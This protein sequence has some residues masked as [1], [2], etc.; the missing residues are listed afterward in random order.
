LLQRIQN[1]EIAG[2][3]SAAIV[4]DVAHRLMTIEAMGRLGWPASGLAARLKKHRAE[5]SKLHLYQQATTK[6][7]QLVCSS[8]RLC[9]TLM[10][11][12]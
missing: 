5:V 4:S 6:V 8:S 12:F 9:A 1:Q 2:H 7:G 10:A 11:G 3:T